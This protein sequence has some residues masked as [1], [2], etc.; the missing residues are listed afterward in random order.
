LELPF[1]PH[2]H[3]QLAGAQ[4]HITTGVGDQGLQSAGAELTGGGVADR[5]D[6]G[7]AAPAQLQLRE[8][9]AVEVPEPFWM[10][11]E[12]KLLYLAVA[13]G[14]QFHEGHGQGP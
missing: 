14:E 13:A 8:A 2:D 10:L 3:Q 9:G 11:A 6:Q 12:Q 1:A 5:Q 7:T 4:A